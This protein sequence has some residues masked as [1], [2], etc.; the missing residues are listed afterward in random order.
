[1][2]EA[3]AS[4]SILSDR[5]VFT[6]E[7]FVAKQTSRPAMVLVMGVRD[8]IRLST[9]HESHTGRI[10]LVAPN[11]YRSIEAA[12]AGLYSIQ[13][14]PTG[15]LCQCLLNPALQEREIIDLSHRVSGMV[16][17]TADAGLDPAQRFEDICAGSQR[18]LDALFPE[19]KRSRST[20]SRVDTVTSWLWKHVPIRTNPQML[21]SLCGLSE[22]RLAHLFASVTG[23]SIRTYL[24]W[25]KMC[26]AANLFSTG[27]TLTEVAHATGFADLPH[28]SRTVRKYFGFTPSF[29]SNPQLVRIEK[30]EALIL[31][32]F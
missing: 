29:L 1:M 7:S 20:D 5:V 22:S 18:I 15:S 4:L 6:S 16:M 11:V 19:A 8:N 27:L 13:L 14:D 21:A 2:S 23:N 30:N 12:S 31:D 26:S 9:A 10:L 17:R 28:L 3:F 25:I 32:R 24:L